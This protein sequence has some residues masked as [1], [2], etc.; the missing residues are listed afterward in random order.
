LSNGRYDRGSCCGHNA[1]AF[2]NKE[3][4]DDGEY[5]KEKFHVY[6]PICRVFSS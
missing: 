4:N 5:F 1:V 3:E 6:V 2:K